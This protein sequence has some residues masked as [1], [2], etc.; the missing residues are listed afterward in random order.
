MSYDAACSPRYS[1]ACRGLRLSHG[2]SDTGSVP[3]SFCP[4]DN[5]TLHVYERPDGGW[6]TLKFSF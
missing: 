4:F 6:G 1:T 5:A 2:L 3:Y